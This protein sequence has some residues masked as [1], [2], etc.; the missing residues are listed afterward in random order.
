M[1]G[2]RTSMRTEEKNGFES[3]KVKSSATR[4]P[5]DELETNTSKSNSR[6]ITN[7][8]RNC[9]AVCLL[10]PDKLHTGNSTL[11]RIRV[12]C[13]CAAVCLLPPNKLHTG[14]STLLPIRVLCSYLRRYR[15]APIVKN[16]NRPF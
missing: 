1:L 4:G 11:L 16:L 5:N 3:R 14:N 13:N 8:S 15:E 2:P 6:I 7:T 12:L 9:A 10:P